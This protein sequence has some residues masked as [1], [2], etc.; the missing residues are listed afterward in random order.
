M[1]WFSSDETNLNEELLKLQYVYLF[2][3]LYFGQLIE[4]V[5]N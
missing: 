3:T 4:I 5:K 2:L 1:L